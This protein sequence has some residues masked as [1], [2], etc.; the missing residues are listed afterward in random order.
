[1]PEIVSNPEHAAEL[2]LSIHS[3]AA[4]SFMTTEVQTKSWAT[5]I[6]KNGYMPDFVSLP[7]PYAEP[8]NKSACEHIDVVREKL[9][10]W[11]RE[12]FVEQLSEPAHCSNPLGVAVKYDANTDKLKFRPVLDLSR[13]VNHFVASRTVQLDDLSQVA[14]LIEPDDF[15][16]AFDL[17]NQFF[18]VRLLPDARKYFGFAVPDEDGHVKFYQFTVMVYGLKSAV[19][20]I[21]R[22]L[23]PLKA[24][25]HRLGIKFSIYV[26]DGRCVAAT[27]D[28]VFWQQ[29]VVLHIFQ[30][31]GWNIN[32]EKT[33]MVPTQMLLYQGFITDSTMMKYVTPNS[34]IVILSALL[35]SLL[36]LPAHATVGVKN[37]ALVLGKIVSMLLSHG[38]VLRVLSRAAQHILGQH[39]AQFGWEGAVQLSEQCRT[40]FTLLLDCLVT[41]NGQ[42]IYTAAAGVTVDISEIQQLKLRCFED[43]IQLAVAMVSDVP[44]ATAYYY[45]NDGTFCVIQDFVSSGQQQVIGEGV[46]EL[47]A[48]R[49]AL[50]T[51]IGRFPAYPANIVFWPTS[52]QTFFGLVS[53]G[54]RLPYLQKIVYEIK[55]LE[56]QFAI[57]VRP[58]WMPITDYQLHLECVALQA[59]ASTDEWSVDRQ[60]LQLIFQTTGL[61]PEVDCFSASFNTI[62]Q[63]FFSRTAHGHSAGVNFFMQ[64][65]EPN[66]VYFCCPPVHLIISC[67]RR[68]LASTDIVSYFLFPDWPSAGFWPV[69]FPLPDIVKSVYKIRAPFFYANAGSSHVFSANPNFDMWILLLRT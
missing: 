30:L 62:C 68:L 34:K 28:R 13:H 59:A 66:I 63:K 61:W 18:H 37:L 19:H 31:A 8:N 43:S 24:Y 44:L 54:S 9:S 67:Y 21:T 4:V 15:L 10:E 23:L 36:E 25:I 1:L 60:I 22:L 6:L 57:Q 50:Q 65:L 33:V 20:V 42:H 69:I 41:F 12:G 3:E 17:K 45:K 48:L 2:Q 64:T 7:T 39:V 14:D 56:R 5:E 58:L 46:C 35:R 49:L 26:D 52:S 51:Y 38:T 55:L 29:T 40:E 27:A 47:L 11:V 32:W 53:R 16:L